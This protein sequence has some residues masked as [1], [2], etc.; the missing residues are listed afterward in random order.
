MSIVAVSNLGGRLAVSADSQVT[1]C[2]E[3]IGTAANFKKIDKIGDMVLAAVG[4]V[5]EVSILK[6][7]IKNNPMP[8]PKYQAVFQYVSNFYKVRDSH[9]GK[10]ADTDNISRSSFVLMFSGK[11]Y[12][13]DNTFIIDI[14]NGKFH[15]IGRGWQ[16][17]LG[18][19]EMGGDTEDAVR[20]VC[21]R[22]IYC[23]LPVVTYESDYKK[24]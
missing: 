20:V 1:I 5:D 2:D 12:L 14:K 17:A 10:M 21:S 13:I 8:E 18:V 11:L 22:N 15:A 6:M 23:S 19:M 3:V 9:N 7:Y 4:C 24:G 16:M